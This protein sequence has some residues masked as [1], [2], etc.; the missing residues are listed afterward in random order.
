MAGGSAWPSRDM[1]V[2]RSCD[3]ARRVDE[4]HERHRLVERLWNE[5]ASQEEIREV[6]GWRVGSATSVAIYEARA[7]GYHLPYRYTTGRR[8]GRKFPEQVAA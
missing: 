2:C 4:G 8:A 3:N 5:G 6:L 7:A 1:E